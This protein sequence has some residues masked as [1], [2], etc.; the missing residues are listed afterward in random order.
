MAPHRDIELNTLNTLKLKEDSLAQGSSYSMREPDYDD[1]LSPKHFRR[2]IDSFKREPTSGFFPSDHLSQLDSHHGREHD[3]A[4]YYDLRLATLE[5][6]HSALARKLKGRHLQMIAIGG[7][8]GGLQHPHTPKGLSV[9]SHGGRL[10][11]YLTQAPVCSWP[12][13]KPWLPAGLRHYCWPSPSSAPC[14]TARARP[15]VN[16]PSYS[17]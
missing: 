11:F 13:V 16:W 9:G 4:H 7:S 10:T 17:P 8:I 14:F 12:L 15:W 6:A 2:F 5:N 1:V 3:G